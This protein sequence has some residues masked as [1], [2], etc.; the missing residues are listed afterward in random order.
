ME[1]KDTLKGK[2]K[3]K[4][5]SLYSCLNLNQTLKVKGKIM[6]KSKANKSKS[7]LNLKAYTS[8]QEVKDAF[9]VYRSQPKA[10]RSIMKR[11]VQ[12]PSSIMNKVCKSVPSSWNE[13]VIDDVKRI[14]TRNKAH[15]KASK[16]SFVFTA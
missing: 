6:A 9:K 7:N 1:K 4:D 14:T 3:L 13:A 12:T 15:K 5:K 16:L 10:R 2:K 8:G 11:F